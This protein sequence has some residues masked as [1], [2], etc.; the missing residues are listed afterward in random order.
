MH[1]KKC[2][3]RKLSQ[4]YPL[5]VAYDNNLFQGNWQD[6][7]GK[8]RVPNYRGNIRLVLPKGKTGERI[9]SL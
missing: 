1:G 4:P 6:D 9:K 8:T 3:G 7:L 5:R 2:K